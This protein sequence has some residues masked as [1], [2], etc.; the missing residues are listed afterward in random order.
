MPEPNSFQVSRHSLGHQ[1]V[2]QETG[3]AQL[4]PQ[5]RAPRLP[6]PGTGRRVGAG[7][8]GAEAAG[9]GDAARVADQEVEPRDG[10]CKK[11]GEVKRL[12]FESRLLEKWNEVHPEGSLPSGS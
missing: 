8:A 2:C 3:S 1:Q 11:E 4:R 7:P 9:G 12:R 6:V 10:G 5:Q